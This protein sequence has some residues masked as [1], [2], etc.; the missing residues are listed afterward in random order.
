[1]HCL[2]FYWMDFLCMALLKMGDT[3]TNA[4]LDAYHG[5]FTPTADFP[6]GIYHYH[7]TAADLY[8]NGSGFYGT[9]GT[10]SQ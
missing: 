7:I 6:Q 2:V 9:A 3:I 5:H 4:E 8:I 1:M 10:V